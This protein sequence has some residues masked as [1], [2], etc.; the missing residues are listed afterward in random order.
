MKRWLSD[1][2][3]SDPDAMKQIQEGGIAIADVDT[4]SQAI[5]TCMRITADH[6]HP[7]EG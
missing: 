1:G 3:R 5:T 6:D 2:S 7:N 4:M